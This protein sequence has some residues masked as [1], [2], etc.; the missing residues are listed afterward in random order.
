M[1]EL[2]LGDLD[3]AEAEVVLEEGRITSSLTLFV[4]STVSQT[5]AIERA[6]KIFGCLIQQKSGRLFYSVLALE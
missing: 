1:E 4:E 3:A 2:L 5:L 6:I